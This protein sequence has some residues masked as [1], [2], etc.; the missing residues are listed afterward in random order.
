[1][2]VKEVE[3]TSRVRQPGRTAKHHARGWGRWWPTSFQEPNRLSLIRPATQT[4]KDAFILVCVLRMSPGA[5]RPQIRDVLGW[6]DERLKD[7]IAGGR[8][9]L[10]RMGWSG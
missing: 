2:S 1:M 10:R 4:E 7:A 8:D 6:D 5:K 9:M 3:R